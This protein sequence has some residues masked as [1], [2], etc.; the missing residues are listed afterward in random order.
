MLQK[1]LPFPHLAFVTAAGGLCA[2]TATGAAAAPARRAP[3]PGA[4]LA[5]G[6]AVRPPGAQAGDLP[7][8]TARRAACWRPRARQRQV[9]AGGGAPVGRR[10][11][12]EHAD[13][14][15]RREHDRPDHLALLIGV[16][17]GRD[18]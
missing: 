6:V 11:A 10:E 5:P 3:G 7:R 9:V 2:R 12:G 1:N 16:V 15:G 13:A 4:R 18:A 8:A 14:G 17:C